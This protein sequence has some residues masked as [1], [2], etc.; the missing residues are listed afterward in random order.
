MRL[1]AKNEKP[2]PAPVRV[3][4]QDSEDNTGKG[5]QQNRTAISSLLLSG[6]SII[7]R[8]ATM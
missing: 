4:K 7:D 1:A 6:A 5:V 3:S 2:S 8:K